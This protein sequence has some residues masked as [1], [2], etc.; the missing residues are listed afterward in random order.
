MFPLTR[1]LV[2]V[3]FS[4]H[5]LPSL[6]YAGRLARGMNASICIVN[7]I[8][9]RDL[10][11]AARVEKVYPALTVAEYL[12]GQTAERKQLMARMIEEAGIT[13]L[14]YSVVVRP[15]VPFKELLDTVAEERID[16]VVMATRGRGNLALRM[17]GSTA[18]KMFRRSPVPVLSIRGDSD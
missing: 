5:S 4:R 2:P 10:D 18:E 7:V 11:A 13:D 15:G 1:I 14:P 17:F 3:D 6:T 8:N 9:Q 12:E 16:L